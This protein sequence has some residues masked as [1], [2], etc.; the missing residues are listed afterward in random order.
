MP[1]HFKQVTIVGVGLIGGSLGM[2]LKQQ[3]LADHVIGVGRTI[4]NLELAIKLG[5]IDR[6]EQE[7]KLAMP[8]TDLV[9]LATPIES[10]AGHLKSWGG[11]LTEGAIV[12]DV[13]SV[14]GPLV[15][16]AESLMP[17]GVHFVGAHP[18]AGKEKSG[19]GAAS[20]DLYQNAL[21]LLT[22]T[23]N[24]DAEALRK[25]Q[26]MWEAAGST[27]RSIDPFVHDWILGAVSHLPHVAAFALMNAL[28]ELQ[29]HTK[30]DV[31]LL[32]F[33]GGGLRDTTRI[34]ASSPEMWRDIFLWNKDNLIVMIEA[35]EKQLG[36]MKSFIQQHDEAGI[37]HEIAKA[38]EAR[39]RLK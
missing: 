36:K 24:T 29:Q 34:A 25:V 39:Q 15:E 10:Y 27:V 13:G 32:N 14:K 5:A 11:L 8:G 2:I 18:I 9:I 38:R 17:P 37:E 26:E 21:C 7:P 4:E 1:I 16:Q 28:S 30:G 6:Y 3:E 12:S 33:S 19:A 20:P 23:E 22:P 35:L 31:D